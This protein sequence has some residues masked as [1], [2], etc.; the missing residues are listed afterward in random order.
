MAGNGH[1]APANIR[2]NL[3]KCGEGTVHEKLAI[4]C[5]SVSEGKKYLKTF[6]YPILSKVQLHYYTVILHNWDQ[7]PWVYDTV[8]TV[9][10]QYPNL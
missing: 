7:P 4:I 6:V 9:L 2:Y 1:F 5:L 10:N 8:W 3:P